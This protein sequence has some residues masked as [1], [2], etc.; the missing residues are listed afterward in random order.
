MDMAIDKQDTESAISLHLTDRDPPKEVL[1]VEKDGRFFVDGQEIETSEQVRDI[2]AR[3]CRQTAG[4][5]GLVW[6]AQEVLKLCG[7]GNRVVADADFLPWPGLATALGLLDDAVN[8]RGW[9][10]L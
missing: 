5:P 3:W 6:A 2:F 1:R 4:G 10:G 7:P 8:A 9:D